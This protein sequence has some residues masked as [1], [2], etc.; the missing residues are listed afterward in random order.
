MKCRG[1]GGTV[2]SGSFSWRR[3]RPPAGLLTV[4]PSS[5]R[6][7]GEPGAA[8]CG[9]R[10]RAR[11]KVSFVCLGPQPRGHGSCPPSRTL[12]TSQ[13]VTSGP[14]EQLKPFSIPSFIPSCLFLI[15]VFK[16]NTTLPWLVWLSGL[17]TGLQTKGWL[18][19]FTVRAH[20]WVVGQ[21]LS[22]G[23]MRGNHTLVFLSLSFSLPF[24]LPP[25]LPPSLSKNK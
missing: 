21:V 22:R 17:S 24:S 7:Q 4:G 6:R 18:V 25:S 14:V 5:E 13:G 20:A 1:L 8:S 9:G 11:S 10:Q 23:R 16:K 19:Q 3:L 15:K 12:L 2:V